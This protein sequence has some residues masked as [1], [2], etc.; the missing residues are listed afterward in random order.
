MEESR[1][2]EEEK[3]TKKERKKE[4]DCEATGCQ[5][6]KRDE[7]VQAKPRKICTGGGRT[8]VQNP[9][10]KYFS[11]QFGREAPPHAAAHRRRPPGRPGAGPASE[12]ATV[13]LLG[14]MGLP[15]GSGGRAAAQ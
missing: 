10:E 2:N 8:A 9:E 13:I 14:R 3:D 11:G 6:R 7:A 12:G 1:T 15:F 5:Q 4:K